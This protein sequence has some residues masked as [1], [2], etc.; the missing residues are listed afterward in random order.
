M[1]DD[2]SLTVYSFPVVKVIAEDLT[3]AHAVDVVDTS[4]PVTWV[5]SVTLYRS[6]YVVTPAVASPET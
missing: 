3:K 5:L 2:L 6:A 1:W 4:E